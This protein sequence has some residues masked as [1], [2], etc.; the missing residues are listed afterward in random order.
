[1]DYAAQDVVHLP[2]IASQ[3]RE[4]LVELD[5]MSWLVEEQ[6][7]AI[8]RIRTHMSGDLDPMDRMKGLHYLDG[9]G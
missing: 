8:D 4:R 3:Q 9:R 5:R 2:E 6:Q 1:M 7:S